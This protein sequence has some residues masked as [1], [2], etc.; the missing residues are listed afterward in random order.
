M[1]EQELKKID[2][3]EIEGVRFGNAQNFDAMTGVT[4]LVFD[5]ANTCGI[6]ISGGGPA[7]RESFLF[8]P[9][10]Y[11]QSVTALL[12]SGGSA[13][14]LEAASGAMRYLEEREM[15]Y[16]IGKGVVPIV[17]QSCIFD[18]SAVSKVRPDIQMGYDACLDAEKNAEVKSGN[19]GGGTGASVGKICGLRQ[20]QK[21]GIGYAAFSLGPLQ[22]GAVVIVNAFGDIFD[23][24]KGVKVAGLM[25]EGRKH[26]LSTEEVLYKNI[27]KV[28]EGENTT[29]G[30][31][32]TNAAFSQQEC[33]KIA[34]MTRAAFAR[35]I[36][37]V[38]TT[39][40]GDTMYAISLAD[41]K[42]NL[43]VDINLVGILACRAVS[44]AILDAVKSASMG[45]DDYRRFCAIKLGE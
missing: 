42:N 45:E 23:F 44:T 13:Y 7:A 30:A 38:G 43:K 31:V 6:D 20:A 2:I 4:A 28:R 33:C 36:N 37:P 3:R 8:T 1:F 17:P 11:K 14:G 39:G 9:L 32:L 34:S 10:A 5:R 21:A 22:V 24:E 16:K 27:L 35:S 26:F 18:L 25:D 19:F 12:L 41:E 15:G 29:I 40:D